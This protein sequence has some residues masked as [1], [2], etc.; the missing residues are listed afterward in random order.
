ML[1]PGAR[2]DHSAGWHWQR[3]ADPFVVRLVDSV[4]SGWQPY[5]EAAAREWSDGS[6]VLNI[7][8]SPGASDAATRKECPAPDG[9]VRICNADYGDKPWAA[10]TRI[11]MV[12]SHIVRAKIKLN[13]R[14]AFAFRA[15][16]CHE[17]GHALGLAHRSPGATSSCLTPAVASSQ[18]HPDTHDLRQLKRIYEHNDGAAGAQSADAHVH[19][20]HDE[21]IEIFH[22]GPYTIVK[23]K[24]LAPER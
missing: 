15:L 1:A 6:G 13:D 17:M 21:E 3:K 18:K 22:R 23:I 5:V 20:A 11:V 2:A 7:S 19:E 12:G 10:T 24:T 8:V 4:T 9:A 16:A 14:G